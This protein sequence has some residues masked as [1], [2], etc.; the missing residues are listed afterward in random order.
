MKTSTLLGTAIGFIAGVFITKQVS[1]RSVSPELALKKVKQKFPEKIDG[2]WI[3]T[4][5]ETIALNEL[6]YN[7]YKG[8][9]TCLDQ[10]Y[11]FTV[12]A[13]TGA[14]LELSPSN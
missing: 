12:D 10:H 11:E 8:G 4:T 14:I 9:L 13:E 5:K 2:S 6:D 7:V 1:E 3:Y